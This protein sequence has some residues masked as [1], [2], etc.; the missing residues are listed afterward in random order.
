MKA[1]EL[2]KFKVGH[3]KVIN[4]YPHL[5]DELDDFLYD[6][7]TPLEFKRVAKTLHKIK[8]FTLEQEGLNNVGE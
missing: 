4:K 1:K 6:F 3:L 2:K 7:V 8:K 5:E